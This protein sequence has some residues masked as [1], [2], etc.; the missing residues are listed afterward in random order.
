MKGEVPREMKR[1]AAPLFVPA[2]ADSKLAERLRTE[3]EK[4][5]QVTGWY[6]KVVE[7]SGRKLGDILSATNVFQQETC[8]RDRCRACRDSEKPINCRRTGLL[9]ETS[10]KSCTDAEGK[11]TARYVGETS[12]SAKERY[13]E[14]CDGAEARRADNHMHKHR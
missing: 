14:H 10:C 11:S 3:E 5:G 13:G 4:L 8:G 9:Y 6:Y 7:R 2:T 1:V 12:R